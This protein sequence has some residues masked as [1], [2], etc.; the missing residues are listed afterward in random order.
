MLKI[1]RVDAS[2]KLVLIAL[3]NE[4]PNLNALGKA[5]ARSRPRYRYG[6]ARQYKAWKSKALHGKARHCMERQ[7]MAWKVKE[8]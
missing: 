2:E 8:R 4:F 6:K 7:G 5:R 3:R 1:R